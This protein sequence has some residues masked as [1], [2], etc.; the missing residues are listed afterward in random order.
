MQRKRTMA[1]VALVAALS[2]VAASCSKSQTSSL[3]RGGIYKME[4]DGFEWT[5]SFDPTGEYLGTAW[6]FYSNLLLRGL[7][8][9]KHVGGTEGNELIPDLATDLGTVS[10]DGLTYTFTL[11]SGVKYAP[12]VNRAVTSKDVAYAFERIGTA[13]L[14]AQYGYYYEPVLKGLTEFKE[15]K[16]TTISGIETPDDKTIK[17]TLLRPAGDFRNLIA[18]PAAAPVPPEVGKCF[19]KAG[20]YGRY[21]IANG[22][23]MIE[24]SDK[25]DITS[26]ATMKPLS[27]FDPTSKLI[28]RRN[29]NYDAATDSKE[30]RSNFIDGVDLVLNTNTEDIFNKIE[31]GT[32]DGEFA[33]PPGTVLQ[34]YSTNSELKDRL[35]ANGADRTWY[36]VLNL[37][38]KPFD[39]L[40]VRRAVNYIIDK[41]GMLRTAGGPVQG[42]IAEHIVP[43]EVLN[44]QLKAGEF[45]PYASPNHAGDEAKAKEEM[46]KSPYDTDKDGVCDAAACKN[47]RHV[48][49]NTPPFKDYAPGIEAALKKIGITLRTTESANAYPT[50]QDPKNKIPINSVAGWGK[51]FANASTFMVLFDGRSILATG[52]SN[53]SL[54]GLTKEK[55]AEIGASYPAGGVPSVDAKIDECAAK[56]GTEQ[57]VCWANLDKY[58]MTDVVPWVPY[59]WANNVD[60]ISKNVQNYQYDQFSGEAALAHV[61]LSSS[62]A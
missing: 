45:D 4:T 57:D 25:L 35:K 6:M 30:A 21:L 20:E 15:G 36:I 18:M 40:N 1:F 7:L 23:Y 22:P 26:C 49:R 55:A 43:P 16:A 46:K 33:T 13:S 28:I 39:D 54:V 31:A 41:E 10:A 52:N 3:K 37:T 34:K 44:G 62:T 61:A 56:S 11:K 14:A 29:P 24:G 60:V 27:G 8:G 5:N 17:F 9:Y 48:T 38:E 47:V 12:P 51:D 58:L 50:I 42:V 53:Y 2:L 19:K 59:R 32:V